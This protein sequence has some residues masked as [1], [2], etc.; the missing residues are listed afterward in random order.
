MREDLE[1]YEEMTK[2]EEVDG[3]NDGDVDNNFVFLH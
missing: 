3:G 2:S 1:G